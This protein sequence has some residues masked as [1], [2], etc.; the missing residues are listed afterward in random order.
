[1]EIQETYKEIQA[2]GYKKTHT[3]LPLLAIVL[4][5]ERIKNFNFFKGFIK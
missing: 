5:F 2:P 3:G 4:Y 1:M